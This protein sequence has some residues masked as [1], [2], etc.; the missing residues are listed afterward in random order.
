[1]LEL[2]TCLIS[3]CIHQT[4]RAKHRKGQHFTHGAA[5]SMSHTVGCALADLHVR[6]ISTRLAEYATG[7]RKE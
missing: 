3:A 1:M 5:C 7:N 2:H 4:V 6:F